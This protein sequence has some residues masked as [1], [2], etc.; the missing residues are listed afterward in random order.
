VYIPSDPSLILGHAASGESFNFYDP[1]FCEPFQLFG[2]RM[3]Q[4]GGL[5]V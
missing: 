3:Y 4:S 2:D 1:I 5:F